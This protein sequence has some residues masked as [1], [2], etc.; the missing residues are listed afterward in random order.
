VT[1]SKGIYH[2]SDT[3]WVKPCKGC[4]VEMEFKMY[5]HARGKKFCTH[6]CYTKY[7]TGLVLPHHSESGR[8]AARARWGDPAERMVVRKCKGCGRKFETRWCS[9]KKFCV[10][11][12]YVQSTRKGS[13][14]SLATKAKMSV[15]SKAAG[16]FK[17][18]WKDPEFR[19]KRSLAS[20]RGCHARPNKP[21]KLVKKLLN[22]MYPGE[23]RYTGSG[24]FLIDSLA[25]DF[26]NV[27]GQKKVIEVFGE[28]Y[29]HPKYAFRK[30]PYR[31]TERG[32]RRTFAKFGYEL[33]VIWSNEI[34]QGGIEGRKALRKKIRRF[35]ENRCY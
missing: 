29:H 14:H 10:H 22:H 9:K 5:C 32:R 23:Y 4:G 28:V 13:H 34:Y 21:E 17:R 26:T 19:R 27:N 2:F 20:I 30:V 11:S 6:K 18:L 33:L 8:K 24:E 16:V 3:G 35:H 31:S 7:L 12:C 15:A 25:P 1:A